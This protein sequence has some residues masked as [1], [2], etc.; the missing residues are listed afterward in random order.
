MPNLAGSG[1]TSFGYI[2]EVSADMTKF[3]KIDTLF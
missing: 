2:G 1:I 3:S